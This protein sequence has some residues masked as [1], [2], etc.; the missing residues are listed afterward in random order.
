MGQE[1]NRRGTIAENIAAILHIEGG[2][3]DGESR[4]LAKR[5]EGHM[6]PEIVARRAMS[7]SGYAVHHINGKPWDN[8]LDNLTLVKLSAP[9]E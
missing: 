7:A 5:I 3:E 9:Q 4:R 8:S 1:M 2:L 6:F